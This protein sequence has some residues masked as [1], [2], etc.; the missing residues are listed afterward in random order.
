MGHGECEHDTWHILR[1]IIDLCW[2]V[3]SPTVC[4]V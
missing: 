4:A 3:E 1:G 2:D